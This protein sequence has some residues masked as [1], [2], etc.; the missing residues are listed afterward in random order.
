MQGGETLIY[1]NGHLELLYDPT[2]WI[3]QAP[4]P[5]NPDVADTLFHT[6]DAVFISLVV[7]RSE[8]PIQAMYEIA[9]TNAQS[10]DPEIRATLQGSRSVNGIQ[11]EF[12]E[13]EAAMGGV[14]F[15]FQSTTIVIQMARFRSSAGPL[16]ILL[17]NIG[18]PSNGW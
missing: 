8:I 1:L 16:Q 3:K 17:R 11:F 18:R 9:I 5:A 6:S 13:M 7:E 14:P 4:D 15:T 2:E 10:V 12:Q